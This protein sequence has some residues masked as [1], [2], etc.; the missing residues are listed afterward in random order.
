LGN[1]GFGVSDGYYS[2]NKN[3]QNVPRF[4]K[5]NSGASYVFLDKEGNH[6][7][8]TLGDGV[9]FYPM[10]YDNISTFNKKSGLESDIVTA[11]TKDPQGNIV[12]ATYP[13]DLHFID[14]QSGQ[15]YRKI[16]LIGRWDGRVK[17]LSFS[18]KGDFWIQTDNYRLDYF[19]NFL[20]KAPP[21]YFKNEKK[22]LEV[23]PLYYGLPR[24][25][26]QQNG[27]YAIREFLDM[28]SPFKNIYFAKNGDFYTVSGVISK[29][30]WIGKDRI[31]CRFFC[32]NTRARF[33]SIAEDKNGVMWFGGTE[34]ICYLRPSSDNVVFVEGDFETMVSDIV[35]LSD[36]YLLCS[37]TGNGVFL[38]KNG[39]IVKKWGMKDGLSSN[40]CNRLLKLNDQTVFVATSQGVTRLNFD[41]NDP[42]R[43]YALIYGGKD[44]KPSLFVN[45]LLLDGERLYIA[46]NEGLYSFK[47]NDLKIQK[48]TPI[49]RLTQPQAFLSQ[50]DT[51]L[52]LHYGWFSQE[53]E[54]KFNF[55]AIA[56]CNGEVMHFRYRLFRDGSLE[57]R[58]ST[59]LSED[60]TLSLVSLISGS[61]ILE[62]ETSRGDAIWSKPVIARFEVEKP[63]YRKP[64][65]L[66]VYWLIV[67]F[68]TFQSMRWRNR[69]RSRKQRRVLEQQEERIALER[70]QL[71]LEQ[72]AVRARIDP[73]FVFNALNGILTF[74]YKKDM[75]SLKIQLPR[76]ARF[77]RV[78]LN[79]GREDFISIEQE[80][81]YLNDYLSLEKRRF[82]EKFEYCI[83]TTEGV[84]MQKKILPPLL[85]QIFIE[86]AIKHGI[87]SLPEGVEGRISIV[88][89]NKDNNTLRCV[90]TDNGIGMKKSIDEKND[91]TE[92][93][94]MGLSLAKR[95][96]SLLN[97]IYG[98][99]YALD[100]SDNEVGTKVT[101]EV[102]L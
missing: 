100:I 41:P 83:S 9:F 61:Y 32:E 78:S 8:C 97:Q 96:V 73:H 82:E 49:L 21:Q 94:S 93:N 72:E 25:I 10:G 6:W 58:D 56:F 40:S 5:M 86:N 14:K 19:P 23:L 36:D 101:L 64:I 48:N 2:L 75:D 13:N 102:K 16:H 55:R 85:L 42:S 24:T 87:S 35:P 39:Q 66:L 3:S 28:V 30:T 4:Y 62:V 43:M 27:E 51:F 98:Q 1:I 74:V 31:R 92:Y 63:I 84:E 15:I 54:I 77:I 33:Y 11:I 68:F 95:R 12:A 53:S 29:A 59:A 47:I 81:Q 7:V 44:A 46:S 76:L 65:A 99:K 17:K 70:R 26:R 52:Q 20:E 50:P 57:K 71:E 91:D 60:F 89:D 67:T 90:I 80:V 79:L 37:T 18:N 88:F 34:G 38:L 69:R 22:V 45:D